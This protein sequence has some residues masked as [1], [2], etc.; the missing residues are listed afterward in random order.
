MRTYI[1][2]IIPKIRRFSRKLDDLTLLTNQHWV[3]IDDVDNVKQVYIF[4]Q[5][6]ELLIS[7]NGKVDKA[8]WEYLGDNALLI[9]LKEESYLL[10]HGF[11]DENILALKIDGKEEYALLVNETKYGHELNSSKSVI[12]FL[13]KKYINNTIQKSYQTKEVN[14]LQGYSL[15][16]ITKANSFY[17]TKDDEYIV[18]YDDGIKGKVFL[19]NNSEEAYF[20]G[21]VDGRFF[22]TE[23]LYNNIDNCIAALHYF[24][25][26]DKVYKDGLVGIFS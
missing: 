7:K 23:V 18:E 10:K 6:N 3:V 14:Q 22:K 19:K 15:K 16:K 5:N 17:S 25:T 24:L 12:E 1:L 26:K 4:R 8:K 2:D 13:T 11:F 20:I 9:D 21:K